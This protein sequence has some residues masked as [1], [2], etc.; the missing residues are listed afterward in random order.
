MPGGDTLVADLLHRTG[1]VQLS[2][3]RGMRQADVMPLEIML[4]DPPRVI[5]AAGDPRTNEDRMLS[6]PALEALDDTSRLRFDRSLLWCGGPTI[7]RAAERLA[8]V[9]KSL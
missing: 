6:H 2:A 1:F 4:A 9:R 3:S 5:F 8:D 7:I